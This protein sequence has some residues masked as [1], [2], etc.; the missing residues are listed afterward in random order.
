M[1]RLQQQVAEVEQQLDTAKDTAAQLK[2][3]EREAEGR[4]EDAKAQLQV[5]HAASTASMLRPPYIQLV[6]MCVF[7]TARQNGGE[8][9]LTRVLLA[10]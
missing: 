9:L 1:E 2:A 8:C 6:S 7:T 4:L 10:C 3:A 5:T